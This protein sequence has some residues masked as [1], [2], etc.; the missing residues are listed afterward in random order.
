M[1]IWL[2][3]CNIG[4]DTYQRLDA[5]LFT[6]L[7]C[8]MQCKLPATSFWPVPTSPCG[9]RYVSSL[10]LQCCSCSTRPWAAGLHYQPLQGLLKY[11]LHLLLAKFLTLPLLVLTPSLSSSF[12]FNMFDFPSFSFHRTTFS[13]VVGMTLRMCLSLVIIC[14][15]QGSGK[16]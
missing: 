4:F 2:C 7:T 10:V 5:H 16:V 13:L 15:L 12:S 1:C 3:R 14:A 9:F 11:I 6:L 8:C